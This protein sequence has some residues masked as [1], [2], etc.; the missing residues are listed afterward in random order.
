MQEAMLTLSCETDTPVIENRKCRD[1]HR[2]PNNRNVFLSFGANSRPP[3]EERVRFSFV[4]RILSKRS[5]EAR[6]FM[7]SKLSHQKQTEFSHLDYRL[8]RS[9]GSIQSS[10]FERPPT[11]DGDRDKNEGRR[12]SKNLLQIKTF[13]VVLADRISLGELARN[14]GGVT[15]VLR[16]NGS[17][18]TASHAEAHNEI[19]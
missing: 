1:Q 13:S 16:G 7:F 18:I 19:P 6:D 10:M 8:I 5:V 11:V 14:S 17:Y 15:V 3:H 12:Q 4:Q 2:S 9:R